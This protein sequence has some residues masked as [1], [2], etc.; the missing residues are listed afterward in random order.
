VRGERNRIEQG[1]GVIAGVRPS[2]GGAADSELTLIETPSVAAQIG[3]DTFSA[4]VN[5]HYVQPYARYVTLTAKPVGTRYDL[6]FLEVWR[7][8]IAVPETHTFERNPDGALTYSIAQ[9][10]DNV[11]QIVWRAGIGGDNF[12]LNEIQSDDHAWVVTKYRL[13]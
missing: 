11:E 5:G 3:F 4:I 7:E 9:V 8:T 13:G 12:D 2:T 6:V 1:S 10:S